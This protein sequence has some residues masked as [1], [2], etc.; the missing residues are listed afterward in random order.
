KPPEKDASISISTE[1]MKGEEKIKVAIQDS[2]PG[3][4]E[5]VQ[6]KLFDPFFTTK[7]IGKGTGI[8]MSISYQIITE[9]HHGELNCRSEINQGACFEITL[10]VHHVNHVAA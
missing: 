10:P 9:K 1:F 3:I 4:P 5:E 7:P 6:K 8:G 2:G